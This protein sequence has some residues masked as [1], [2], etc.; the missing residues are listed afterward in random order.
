MAT[1][2]P[3]ASQAGLDVLKSGGN[4]ADAAIAANAM[5]GIVEP[6][7]CGIGGDL[8]VI[9]W[10]AKTKQ[11]TA[12]TAADAAPTA[13]TVRS[14]SSA[15]SKTFP[16]PDPELVR[17][18]LR[19]RLGTLRKRFGA[20]PLAELLSAG[21]EAAEDGFPLSEII[22]GYWQSTE[23]ALKK[24]PD[25]AKT[26]LVDGKRAPKTGEIFRNPRL[27]ANYRLI[28]KDGPDAFYR[29][30]IAEA[31][32]AASKQHGGYMTEKDLADHTTDW[33]E[34]VSTNYRGYDVWEL[35]P[36][37]QGIAALEMLNILEQH[38]LK[39]MGHNSADHLHLFLEAK[40][41]A[42]ADRAKFYA[43][44]AF[45]ELPTKELISKEYGQRQNKRSTCPKPRKKCPPAIPS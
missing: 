40:K 15:T 4:A 36:N 2:H 29:G 17:A 34:P 1:S 42:F 38:D 28:S 7:S 35:P 26:L 16:P 11:L 32:A 45:G 27:A 30:P 3:L 43:D 19:A 12:S 23:A 44:P 10:D 24:W 5:Q 21:I 20:K 22:A 39:K 33:V 37:G 41:L 6:M 18:R 13:S 9:Y 14:S 31:I 8:L 25:S